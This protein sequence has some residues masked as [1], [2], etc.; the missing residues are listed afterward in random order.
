M[1]NETKFTQRAVTVIGAA[2]TLPQLLQERSLIL[3]ALRR[4]KT[5]DAEIE[6]IARTNQV[7][8]SDLTSAMRYFETTPNFN[9]QDFSRHERA[10]RGLFG[11]LDL[12]WSTITRKIQQLTDPVIQQLAQ[13]TTLKV[14]E[15]RR[16][17][18]QL[19]Q[20]AAA[21]TR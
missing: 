9:T 4:I 5:N 19:T 13:Q 18:E 12:Q 10:L 7:P 21:E 11:G 3:E 17:I 20:Y 6:R 2:L 8:A 16:E 1:Q 15:V 14:D